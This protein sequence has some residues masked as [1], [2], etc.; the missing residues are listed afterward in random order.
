MPDLILLRTYHD[1]KQ[2]TGWLLYKNIACRTVEPPWMDNEQNNSCII[3]DTYVIKK[4]LLRGIIPHYE[5]IDVLGRTGIFIHNGV[6]VCDTKGCICAQPYILR[7][8]EIEMGFCD[9]ILKIVE[10]F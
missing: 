7:E 2:T 4:G 6:K 8:I 3:A 10:C 9:A 1:E 5:L